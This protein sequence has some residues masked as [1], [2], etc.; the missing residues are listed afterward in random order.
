MIS[1]K[2][3]KRPGTKKWTQAQSPQR[4][5]SSCLSKTSLHN[6]IGSIL[7][8]SLKIGRAMRPTPSHLEAG[9]ERLFGSR[10]LTLTGL[11]HGTMANKTCHIRLPITE[12]AVVLTMWFPKSSSPHSRCP[13]ALE[14]ALVLP[15]VKVFIAHQTSI[16]PWATLLPMTKISNAFSNVESIHNCSR[17]KLI[18][19][20]ESLTQRASAPTG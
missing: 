5:H 20:G 10:T 6:L 12:F 18:L 14:S 11:A 9:L 19:S 8:K 4:K 16:L 3:W 1:R 13:L 7:D 15:M 17:R 2:N